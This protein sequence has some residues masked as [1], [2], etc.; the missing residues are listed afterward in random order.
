MTLKVQLSYE[1]VLC[2]WRCFTCGGSTD[3][4][5][6]ATVIRGEP[7]EGA[8][9]GDLYICRRCIESGPSS[10]PERLRH[11]A[12]LYRRWADDCE[13][14]AGEEWEMPTPDE[15][16]RAEW[17]SEWIEWDLPDQELRWTY[18]DEHVWTSDAFEAAVRSGWTPGI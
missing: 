10:V 18:I 4:E 17:F 5:A 16:R 6:V 7:G 2:R 8:R 14:L 3:K 13:A 11:Q 9:R 15:V 12:A 1:T